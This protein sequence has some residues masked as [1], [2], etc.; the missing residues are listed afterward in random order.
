AF[1]PDSKT[2][3]AAAFRYRD[4]YLWDLGTGKMQRSLALPN[5]PADGHDVRWLALAFSPDGRTLAGLAWHRIKAGKKEPYTTTIHLWELATG[6][7]RLKLEDP[8]AS[9]TALAFSPDGGVLATAGKDKVIRF[10]DVV[11][12]KELGQLQGH[13]GAVTTVAFLSDGNTLI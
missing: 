12:G 4:L 8:Q 11:T 1:S 6:K 5:S 13:Q 2:L 7:V 3:A 10:W 9:L